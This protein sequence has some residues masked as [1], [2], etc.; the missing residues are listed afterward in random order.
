MRKKIYALVCAGVVIASLCG[1]GAVNQTL[2]PYG[3]G[4]VIWDP[5]SVIQETTEE[6]TT[7]AVVKVP[8]CTYEIDGG[9]ITFTG[10]GRIEAKDGDEIP[11]WLEEIGGIE[12]VKNV[13]I[14]EGIT[15]ADENT[16]SGAKNLESITVPKTLKV[17]AEGFARNCSGLKTVV[18]A[19]GVEEIGESAFSGCTSLETIEIPSTVKS[20]GKN[21]FFN[22]KAITEIVIPDGVNMLGAYAFAMCD[23]LVKVT[24]GKNVTSLPQGVFSQDKALVE[25]NILGV[26]KNFESKAFANCIVI[27]EFYI[28]DGAER[29]GDA[30]FSECNAL[31]KITIPASV[32]FIAV[33]QFKTAHEELIIYCYEGSEAQAHAEK[34]SKKFELITE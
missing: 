29:I 25:C 10:T 3:E 20:I 32:T 31:K 6:V 33:E 4:Q 13:I 19:E 1:C 24:I 7:E 8:A 26:I 14:S 11:A 34:E 16:F 9:T 21:G 2:P 28:P 18:I 5:D 27:E 22:C 15:V 17:I 30:V 12:A 23:N